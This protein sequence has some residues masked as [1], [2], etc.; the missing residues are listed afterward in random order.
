MFAKEMVVAAEAAQEAGEML[1]RM[2]GNAHR[3]VKKGE[4]DLVTE[5]D[6]AAEKVILEIIG[7]HFPGDILAK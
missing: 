7:R 6:F 4:I 2:L 3:I 1:R 5:A